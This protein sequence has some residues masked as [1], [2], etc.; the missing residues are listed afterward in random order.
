[1][2]VVIMAKKDEYGFRNKVIKDFTPEQIHM[3]IKQKENL[4]R[5]DAE[6]AFRRFIQWTCKK[7]YYMLEYDFFTEDSWILF[8]EESA[9]VR[10]EK[11][12]GF[13]CYSLPEKIS[14]KECQDLLKAVRG[15][16]VL[17]GILVRYMIKYIVQDENLRKKFTLEVM[18]KLPWKKSW[19]PSEDENIP[20]W[21]MRNF[22]GKANDILDERVFVKY[23]ISEFNIREGE[24]DNI[25]NEFVRAFANIY[26]FLEKN[27]EKYKGLLAGN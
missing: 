14:G 4:M 7:E 20:S 22:F 26:V 5:L 6:R 2:G 24:D 16:R 13:V 17:F 15:N 11:K 25:P 8:L 1:M 23:L 3:L 18:Q 10:E 19:V 27:S 12:D 9:R 21:G